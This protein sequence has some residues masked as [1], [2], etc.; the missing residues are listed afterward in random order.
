RAAARLPA[1]PEVHAAYLRAAARIEDGAE[2]RLALG[3][4]ADEAELRRPAWSDLFRQSRRMGGGREL[5]LLLGEI[6]LSI[7]AD[8][9]VQAMYL[10]AARGIANDGGRRRALAAL[11]GAR[12]LAPA[13][14]ARVLGQAALL[15]D[16]DME[17]LLTQTAP[18]LSRDA[19]VEQAYRAATARIGDPAARAGALAAYGA[20][21]PAASDTVP[22][23]DDRNP[24]AT[25]VLRR[26]EAHGAERVEQ[27]LI[28]KNVLLT[29]DRSA[30]DRIEPGGWLVF[31]ERAGGT[32]RRV[33]MAPGGDGR[34]RY[35]WSGDFTRQDREAWLRDIFTHF[36]DDTRG[37]R[38][39]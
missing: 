33:R 15:G 19:R 39:W 3:A 6:A 34:L 27:L 11:L 2:L 36:A 5:E 21:R 35:D 16:R 37:Q 32:T 7:P 23:D 22:L 8:A 26:R 12:R 38:Q 18:Y 10:D 9:E 30:I 17:I 4:L 24:E 28:A 25:T 31:R 29:R 20:P 14:Q 13:M 1:D